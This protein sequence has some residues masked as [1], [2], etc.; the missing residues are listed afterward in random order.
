MKKTA[1]LLVYFVMLT[2]S[3]GIN[4]SSAVVKRV[5]LEHHVYQDG[6]KGMKIHVHFTVQG[7]QGEG[8]KCIA[9]F[10]YPKGSGLRDINGKYATTDG[11][12]CC[13][14]TFTP[15]YSNSE[16]SDFSLFIPVSELHLPA[17]ENTIYADV[18]IYDTVR[19]KFLSNCYV[20]FVG[21]GAKK[22]DNDDD[23]DGSLAALRNELQSSGS[24]KKSSNSNQTY[25]CNVCNGTGKINCYLC[26]GSGQTM[27]TQVNYNTG[28]YYYVYM[29][30]RA[31]NG[32]GHVHCTACSG[33]GYITIPNVDRNGGYD[34]NSTIIESNG[35]FKCGGTGT[36]SECGGL[37]TKVNPT[38]GHTL[39]CTYC[40]G[41][42]KCY[43]CKGKGNYHK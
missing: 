34:D 25:S 14:K 28:S 10:E 15:S 42:G 20:S 17:G 23:D 1:V 43:L 22:Y 33:N 4:A 5:W 16:Y 24:K 3:M 6:V 36:C 41:S 37:G 18:E 9:Y 32:T 29:N 11:H 30:C 8:G 39:K 31:C 35:C 26:N 21:T 12:V 38:T 2:F 27:Q 40:N 7:M 19:K 13:S